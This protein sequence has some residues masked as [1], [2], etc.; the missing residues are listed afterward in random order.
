MSRTLQRNHTFFEI[1]SLARLN[2]NDDHISNFLK[3]EGKDNSSQMFLEFPFTYIKGN[4]FIK[5]L[6]LQ[7]KW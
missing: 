7:G 2:K 3:V 1:I 5:I 6:K 4:T